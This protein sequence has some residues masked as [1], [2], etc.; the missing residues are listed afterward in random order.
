MSLESKFG[1]VLKEDTTS[2][3]TSKFGGMLEGEA[4]Q[5]IQDPQ[6]R[7]QVGTSMYGPNEVVYEG[8][9]DPIIAGSGMMGDVAI[10]TIIGIAALLNNDRF[11]FEM[12][13]RK[14]GGMP[15]ELNRG[16][17]SILKCLLTIEWLNLF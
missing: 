4:I 15:S 2:T 6:I 7:E 8:F 12:N 14:D 9:V 16:P 17:L 13:A 5:P 10:N 3:I 11:V 1:G